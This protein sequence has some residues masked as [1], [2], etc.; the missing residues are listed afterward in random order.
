M[1]PLPDE[2]AVLEERLDQLMG[3][4]VAMRPSE[5]VTS[6]LHEL[7]RWPQQTGSAIQEKGGLAAL[8]RG[9]ALAVLNGEV[10][11]RGPE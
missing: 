11:R 8:R 2:P 10:A 7:E 5:A 1:P 4:L 9:A 6:A 3:P